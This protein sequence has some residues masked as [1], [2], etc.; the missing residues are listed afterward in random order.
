LP[1]LPNA[2]ITGVNISPSEKLMA[3]YLN[4]DRSPA[5]LY[6][7]DFSS[8]KAT[9][10]TD[11]LNPEI[12]PAD[13]VDSTVIRYKSFD[14]VD[15]PSILYKPKNASATSKAPA[16]L[17]VHGGPGGP[18]ARWLQC[19]RAVPRK[20]RLCDSRC[21]QSWLEWLWQVVLRV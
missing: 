5:N 9:K 18:D 10:L 11:S 2:D 15:I 14:G 1:Q 13:L 16:L 6:V 3:F 4:G 17:L 12:N 7:Y 20:S 8:K 19:D 21:Q